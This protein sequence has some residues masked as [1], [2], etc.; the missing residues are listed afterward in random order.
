MQIIWKLFALCAT[1]WLSCSQSQGEWH[2]WCKYD[3]CKYDV[4]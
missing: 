3:R 4:P 1:D 2:I